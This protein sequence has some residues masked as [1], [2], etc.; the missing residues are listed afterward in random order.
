MAATHR[1]PTSK[2]KQKK[3]GRNTTSWGT[4]LSLLVGIVGV[5]GIVAAV[6]WPVLSAQATCFDD[7]EFLTENPLVQHP[8][9]DAAGRFLTEIVRPSTVKGYYIPLT[10]ISLM[11]DHAL[12]GR[13]TDLRQFH[14]TNLL[15]HTLSVTA[16]ILLLYL[17]FGTVWPAVLLA[18]LYGVHPLTVEPIA[19]IAERKTVLATC[20]ALWSI[21]FYLVHVR[22]E[23]GF[24]LVLSVVLFLLSLLAKP[25]TV[26]LPV[27]LLLL[28]YWPLGRLNRRAIVEKLPYFVLACASAGITIVSNSQTAKVSLGSGDVDMPVFLKVCHNLVFYPVKVIW[29]SGLTPYYPPPEPFSLA[30]GTLWVGVVGTAAILVGLVVAW[31]WS[32]AIVVGWLFFFVAILPTLGLIGFSWILASDKYVYFPAVGLLLPLAVA[33]RRYWS[34][35][36][37]RR[38]LGVVGVAA[39]GLLY[40]AGVRN[41]LTCWRDTEQLYD[42]MLAIAPD[43]IVPH[44]GMGNELMRQGRIAEAA[45]HYRS[46]VEAG[47]IHPDV[48]GTYGMALGMLGHKREALTFL[49]RALDADPES[50]V[51]LNRLASLLDELG[52]TELALVHLNKALHLDPDYAY[53]HYHLGV[54]MTRLGRFEEA[55]GHFREAVGINPRFVEAHGNL[56]LALERAGQLE[57]ALEHYRTAVSL[58]PQNV[59]LRARLAALLNRLGRTQEAARQKAE[60]HVIQ[61]ESLER[62]GNL[63]EAA[64]HYREALRAVPGHTAAASRLEAIQRRGGS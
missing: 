30:N 32:R 29:P 44:F 4:T 24:P 56:A 51:T 50:V 18:L 62:Q 17:S 22:R 7:A 20:L 36:R 3:T 13:A 46:A 53:T 11:V 38:A 54:A 34:G 6:H 59:Q 28:D 8:S 39:L 61:G 23:T 48:L 49:N 26:P 2:R 5:A 55:I 27:L 1:E 58:A 63:G 16:V 9:I 60:M 14:R 45:D 40:A 47:A 31:R 52:E 42:H 25:T 37:A 10:M 64:G 57:E 35:G 12:G 19:W 15:L 33:A 43:A 21:V 41:Y